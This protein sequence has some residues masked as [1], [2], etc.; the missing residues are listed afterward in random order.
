MINVACLISENVSYKQNCNSRSFAN[1]SGIRETDA[2]ILLHINKQ[3]TF[4]YAAK[5]I[6]PIIVI[7]TS[8]NS[9]CDPFKCQSVGY[10][11]QPCDLKLQ[12]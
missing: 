7:I 8:G 9:Y 11:N 3:L 5:F 1:N 10:Y 4:K 12:S 6:E 2:C